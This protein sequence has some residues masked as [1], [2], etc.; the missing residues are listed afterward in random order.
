[1]ADRLKSLKSF[2][3]APGDENDMDSI[4]KVSFDFEKLKALLSQMMSDIRF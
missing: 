4:F 2:A 3:G 1:M